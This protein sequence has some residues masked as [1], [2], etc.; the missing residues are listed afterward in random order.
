[1]CAKLVIDVLVNNAGSG[2]TPD[3]C[4]TA[5]AENILAT[6]AINLTS[7][8]ECTRIVVEFMEKS[9][10]LSSCVKW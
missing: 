2:G 6:M 4:Q 9:G 7:T 1:V 5:T 8:T 3:N 10:M